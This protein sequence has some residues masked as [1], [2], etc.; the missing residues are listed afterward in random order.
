MKRILIATGVLLGIATAANA[1]SL[2]DLNIQF[3]GYAT[4]G[5]L[6]TTNNNILTTNSTDGSPAWTE[7][8]VNVSAQPTPKLHVSVQAR[9]FLLGNFGNAITLDYAMADYKVNDRFGVRFGKVKT[10]SSLF[11]EVQDIDPSYMW[12][13]LP[14]S[15]Y[16]ISSRNSLLSH[17]GGVVYGTVNLGEKLGK[18]EYRG[19]GGEMS[20]G[21]GDGYFL[22]EHDLG[23]NFPN[24]YSSVTSGAA[25]HWKT[26]LPG[27]MIGTSINRLNAS[28]ATLT[29]AIPGYGTFN[30]SLAVN[31]INDPQFFARYEKAKLMFA[32]EY[33][34]LPL[35][36]TTQVPGIFA[37]SQRSD[38]RSWFA[39]ASY[40]LTGKL[41]AGVYDSQQ[42][43]RKAV[44]G[45]ARYQKD[46]AVSGRYDFNEFV[47]AKAEQHFLDGTVIGYDVA[48][49]PGGLKPTTRL[50]IIKL[51][52]SF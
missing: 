42:V 3:H 43:D 32:G 41:T 19:W 23:I 45:P 6:Y 28:T 20:L 15:I 29:A 9:Y 51:G 38:F 12:S 13:L 50:T 36:D 49:N 37:Q 21:S 24:G 35:T 30:G 11:N 52:V 5:F 25:L 2:D 27:L 8:V 48:L 10:P 47:Y 4:Q 22:S 17:Y 18:L 33:Q 14:Q 39:M 34:R 40:K 46:W 7:A 26:P 1:Q 31:Q 16:P 44:L